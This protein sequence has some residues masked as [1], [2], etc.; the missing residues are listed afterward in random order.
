MF[1]N[2]INLLRGIFLLGIIQKCT[3]TV[4]TKKTRMPYGIRVF[5]VIRIGMTI[6]LR[7]RDSNPNKQSQSLSCYLYTN[8]QNRCA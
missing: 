8:P 3:T 6:W 7:I 2:E 4:C 1:I 5:V